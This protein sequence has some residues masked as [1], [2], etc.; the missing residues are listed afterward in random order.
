MGGSSDVF[1]LLR[2]RTKTNNYL[3]KLFNDLLVE[4]LYGESPPCHV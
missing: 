4:A 2:D 3:F 1:K